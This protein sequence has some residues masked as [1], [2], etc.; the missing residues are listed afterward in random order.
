MHNH[1][2]AWQEASWL[3]G[4]PWK[5]TAPIGQSAEKGKTQWGAVSFFKK[6]PR[7]AELNR[8]HTDR[9]APPRL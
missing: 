7:L 8:V 6:E 4:G 3:P 9:G 2:R 5:Q 1:G